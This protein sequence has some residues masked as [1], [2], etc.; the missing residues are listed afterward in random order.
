LCAAHEFEEEG[1]GFRLGPITRLP[2][3]GYGVPL[4]IW[5]KFTGAEVYSGTLAVNYNYSSAEWC[6]LQR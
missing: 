1:F 5:C 3:G 6:S 2:D 4:W